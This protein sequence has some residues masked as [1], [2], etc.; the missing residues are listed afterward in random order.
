MDAY[1]FETMVPKAQGWLHAAA[2]L[3]EATERVG[4]RPL[5]ATGNAQAA[6]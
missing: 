1:G 4:L 2:L 6:K 5:S 3:S